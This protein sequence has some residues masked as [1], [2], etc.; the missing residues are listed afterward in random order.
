MRLAAVLALCVGLG[1]SAVAA[2]V[3]PAKDGQ[4]GRLM[5]AEL[6]A[7]VPPTLPAPPAGENEELPGDLD[8]EVK[9]LLGRAKA[10][11][12]SDEGAEL[13]DYS[14]DDS[15]H[16][17]RKKPQPIKRAAAAVKTAVKQT[18]S[19][20]KTWVRN[21]WSKA[22]NS[23]KSIARKIVRAVKKVHKFVKRKS[24]AARAKISALGK[25]FKKALH[26]MRRKIRRRAIPTPAPTPAPG[27]RRRISPVARGP[28]G[29]P[30]LQGLQG[31]PGR[32][33]RRGKLGEIGPQGPPGPP[34]G[35]RGR[36]GE[37][38]APGGQGQIGEPG[39]PA[40]PTMTVHCKWAV[41]SDWEP[42]TRT[43]AGG[44]RR[45]E[46]LVEVSPTGGGE[47]CKGKDFEHA[48]CFPKRKVPCPVNP[49]PPPEPK[50]NVTRRAPLNNGTGRPNFTRDQLGGMESAQEAGVKPATPA[51]AKPAAALEER[52]SA[53]SKQPCGRSGR[54][55][56]TGSFVDSIMS[57][58]GLAAHHPPCS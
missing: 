9:S 30:G 27:N 26:W 45:R 55:A 33:G 46:R 42:C 58:L 43:C 31:S 17:K 53:A 22:I 28:P 21:T 3:L 24:R 13:L 52:H 41:W 40:L 4:G 37:Q 16:R 7:R 6:A 25:K 8:E 2:V 29:W 15:L 44:F 20:A 54:P 32:Q 57:W 5:R 1:P 11:M 47:Q 50:L 48:D 18:T 49:T 38:G 23:V 56:V 34:A 14:M 39:L 36:T 35:K 12:P 10:R 51:A 19:R